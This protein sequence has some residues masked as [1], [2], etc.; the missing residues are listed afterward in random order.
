MSVDLVFRDRSRQSQL[1][2]LCKSVIEECHIP[3]DA[4][5]CCIFDDEERS[6]FLVEYSDEFYG[7]FSPVQQFGTAMQPWPAEL[8]EHFSRVLEGIPFTHECVIYVRKSITDNPVATTITFAHLLTHFT[9]YKYHYNSW[10]AC[11]WLRI[12]V[13]ESLPDSPA[14]AIPD[15]YEAELKA[16]QVAASVV[17][18]NL[19]IG[20]ALAQING[21]SGSRK[22]NFFLE[23]NESQW[24]DFE[25]TTREMVGAYR[26]QLIKLASESGASNSPDFSMEDEWW[27]KRC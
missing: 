12:V 24:F 2:P 10:Q 23:L 1:Q 9:Q 20:H 22:W 14:W 13:R 3:D 27:G 6:D 21:G 26:P 8:K 16:K 11:R 19:V 7:F 17:G 25:K 18:R 4:S 15:Q 5:I